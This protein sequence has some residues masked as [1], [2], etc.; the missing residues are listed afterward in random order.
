MDMDI[1]RSPIST[2][3][4]IYE[5]SG[6]EVGQHFYWQIE[7]FQFHAQV[8]INSWVVIVVLQPLLLV[9]KILSNIFLNFFRT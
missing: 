1:V 5:I 8:L 2:L 7:G 3:N 4:H 6:V 9:V